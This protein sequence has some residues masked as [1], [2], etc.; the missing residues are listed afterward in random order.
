MQHYD[1]PKEKGR[2]NFCE[3]GNDFGQL[4]E[5][6]ALLIGLRNY[7]RKSSKQVKRKIWNGKREL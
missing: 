2:L 5:V 4:N 1:Q 6:R 3:P 7:L